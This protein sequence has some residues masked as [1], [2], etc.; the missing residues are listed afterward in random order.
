[1]FVTCDQCGGRFK[2][3]PEKVPSAGVRA[4]CTGCPSVL[5]LWKDGER[6]MSSTVP[7]TPNES[8]PRGRTPGPDASGPALEPDPPSGAE[9][10]PAWTPGPEAQVDPDT[11]P[12]PPPPPEPAPAMAPP[13]VDFASVFDDVA[14]SFDDPPPDPAPAWEAS[15]SSDFREPSFVSDA[16]PLDEANEIAPLEPSPAPAKKPPPAPPMEPPSKKRQSPQKSRLWPRGR[17]PEPEGPLSQALWSLV[18]VTALIYGV[19]VGMEHDPT[20][21]FERVWG[22]PEEAA[23]RMRASDLASGVYPT[24]DGGQLTYLIGSLQ[25]ET[26]IPERSAIRVV[27]E[28][29]D[30]DGGVA[31]RSEGWA[32]A[33]PSPEELRAVIDPKGWE[34][35]ARLI[36]LRGSASASTPFLVAFPQARTPA[37]PLRFRIAASVEA[38]PLPAPDGPVA[39]DAGE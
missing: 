22:R 6:V 27:G 30:P 34:E 11:S 1:M 18:V 7:A 39:Q 9:P 3:A 28:L 4:R 2:I 33:L 13:D 38:A 31:A 36:A 15:G 16:I 24:S 5:L 37:G 35:L 29:L 25:V 23:A 12:P 20:H 10:A 17:Q 19:L 8:P 32:G 21:L 14:G 26:E